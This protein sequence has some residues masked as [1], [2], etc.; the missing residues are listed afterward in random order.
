MTSAGKLALIAAIASGCLSGSPGATAAGEQSAAPAPRAHSLT[1]RRCPA[2]NDLDAALG[3]ASASMG[4]THY[5][6]AAETL[7]PLSGMDCDPR[8]SLL[9]AAAFEA[10]GD[11]AK[12]TEVLQRA[13]SVW[14]SNSSVAASLAREYFARGQVD[15]AVKALAH[16][17]V[18]EGTPLQEMELAVVVYLAAHQLVS[19]QAVAEAANK[20]YPS[21]HTLLLLAN[22]LQLQG[23]YPDV[24]RLLGSKRGTYADSPE[25]FITLA[26]SEFDASIYPAAR[27][28]LEHAISLDSKSYQAHYL[29]G[30]VLFRLNEVDRAVAEYRLAI[31][32]APDQPRTYFH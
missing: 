26:E 31:D 23:R 11:V 24:K 16:F 20:T 3:K 15:Q 10:Q 17:Q 9:L 28:D 27:E 14:P 21:V 4:Q 30:N 25:F 1:N 7:Q 5:Q 13:H 18:T 6:D 19:A 8:V 32:L 2:R 22:A 12:A 29:L